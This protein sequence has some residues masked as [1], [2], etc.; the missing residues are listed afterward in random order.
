[1]KRKFLIGII[2]VLSILFILIIVAFIHK[3]PSPSPSPGFGLPKNTTFEFLFGPANDIPKSTFDSKPVSFCNL[4]QITSIK[5]RNCVAGSGQNSLDELMSEIKYINAITELCKKDSKWAKLKKYN[6]YPANLNPQ[7]PYKIRYSVYNLM[8]TTPSMVSA[9]INAFNN[10][11]YVQILIEASQTNP[12]KSYNTLTELL[13]K[14]GM[15][16]PA[17]KK[18]PKNSDPFCSKCGPPDKTISACVAPAGMAQPVGGLKCPNCSTAYTPNKS[19][20]CACSS[21]GVYNVNAISPGGAPGYALTGKHSVF[22][23]T[24]GAK[25]MG[26]PP[27]ATKSSGTCST[28][29][30]ADGTSCKNTSREYYTPN[31]QKGECKQDQVQDGYCR[32]V[33]FNSANYMGSVSQWSI[34]AN[35]GHSALN[36][37]YNLVPILSVSWNKNFPGIMHTKM[38]L[39]NWVEYGKNYNTVITGS[40]NPEQAAYMNEE[41]LIIMTNDKIFQDYEKI[42]NNVLHLTND[43]PIP[44]FINQPIE[45]TTLTKQVLFSKGNVIQNGKMAPT[46]ATEINKIIALQTEMVLIFCY[47]QRD[48][49]GYIDSVISAV[50]RGAFVAVLFDIDQVVGESG[51]SSPDN[52]CLP[53]QLN[54]IKLDKKFGKDVYVPV[55]LCKNVNGAFSAFHHKNMVVGASGTKGSPMIIT[56]DSANWT[57]AALGEGL[58]DPAWCIQGVK[59]PVDGAQRGTVSNCEGPSNIP[60]KNSSYPQVDGSGQTCTFQKCSSCACSWSPTEAIGNILCPSNCQVSPYQESYKHPNTNS[61]PDVTNCDSPVDPISLLPGYCG[62][63]PSSSK[64]QIEPCVMDSDCTNSDKCTNTWGSGNASTT[65]TNSETT[66]FINSTNHD[67]NVTGL[68]FVKLFFYLVKKYWVMSMTSLNKLTHLDKN[69]A[70]AF[71]K[72]TATPVDIG[73]SAPNCGPFTCPTGCWCTQ[74]QNTNSYCRS[75]SK[76]HENFSSATEEPFAPPGSRIF[77]PPP[78]PTPTTKHGCGETPG[79]PDSLCGLPVSAIIKNVYS[80][81]DIGNMMKNISGLKN[82]KTLQTLISDLSTVKLNNYATSTPLRPAYTNTDTNTGGAALV[83]TLLVLVVVV[84]LVVVFRRRLL[85]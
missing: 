57:E 12:C 6:G 10:G 54:S 2:V 21:S 22:K 24:F 65:T 41:T 15:I 83:V 44:P 77:I 13:A 76:S 58:L 32:P 85:P 80:P 78:T 37:K 14:G 29:H 55:Y 47:T 45:I 49:G 35:E 71:Y 11:V 26:A 23:A 60:G 63:E 5:P 56:T 9:L 68:Q 75:A 18:L 33:D 74:G 30:Y 64:S 20:T 16:V 62:K 59:Y 1:M 51:F 67:G 79:I 53:A 27:N 8:P 73:C 48:W 7:N 82:N 19:I 17:W 72:Q 61:I 81:N 34:A 66:L 28:S 31:Q 36:Y 52:T 46:P 43:S 40:L 69:Y 70:M 42:Y 38:R 25:V 50:L 39:F 84:V 4:S 3:S